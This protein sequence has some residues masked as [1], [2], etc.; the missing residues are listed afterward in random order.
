MALGTLSETVR[1]G[2]FPVALCAAIACD[3]AWRIIP[4]LVVLALLAGFAA[5]AVAAPIADLP[6]RLLLAGLVTGVGFALFAHDILGAG[7]AKLAGALT[8][9]LD[10]AQVPAFML[11]CAGI[12]GLLTL[13]ATL[14]A[15]APAAAA[16]RR[17]ADAL[18]YGVALAGAGLL[19]Q[20][21]SSLAG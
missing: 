8:L 9:W 21:F 5:L 3:L 6:E 14:A 16:L 13:G 17:A 10:P 12:A 11:I 19:L 4:N 18:P 2:V 1:L 7:D 20:P 15:R